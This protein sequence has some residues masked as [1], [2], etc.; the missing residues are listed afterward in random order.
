MLHHF[1]GEV[2]YETHRFLDKNND[3]VHDDLT[4]VLNSSGIP[5]VRNLFAREDEEKTYGATGGRFRSI[6]G[7]FLEQVCPLVACVA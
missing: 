4:G 7:K 2:V 6:S 1:A 5:F 3:T